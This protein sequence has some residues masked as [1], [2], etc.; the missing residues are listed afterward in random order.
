MDGRAPR[1]RKIRALRGLGRLLLSLFSLL[2]CARHQVERTRRAEQSL[3]VGF[4]AVGEVDDDLER[5]SGNL[6]EE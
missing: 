3:A 4:P 2:L 6:A 5:L 1:G